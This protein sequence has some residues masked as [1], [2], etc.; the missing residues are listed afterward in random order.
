MQSAPAPSSVKSRLAVIGAIIVAYFASLVP[1]LLLGR[2]GFLLAALV[3]FAGLPLLLLAI[4]IGALAASR[5]IDNPWKWSFAA[6]LGGL[7]I[8]GAGMML[9]GGS[10]RVALLGLPVAIFG[11]V[12]FRG[13]LIILLPQTQVTPAAPLADN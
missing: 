13:M 1:L 7:V 2:G 5:I 3:G 11:P 12:A 10:W 8:G 6:G 4:I 9:D